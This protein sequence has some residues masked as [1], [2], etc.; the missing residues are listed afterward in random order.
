MSGL[1]ESAVF[2]LPIEAAVA[3]L[4]TPLLLISEALLSEQVDAFTS[5]AKRMLPAHHIHYSV[6]TNDAAPVVEAMARKLDGLEVVSGSELE[7]ALRHTDRI[8]FN[9]PNKSDR[10]L[11]TALRSNVMINLDGLA[12][13][14]RVARIAERLR[15]EP[16]VGVRVTFESDDVWQKF[17]VSPDGRELE[18]IQKLHT[19]TALHHHG[20]P[21]APELYSKLDALRRRLGVRTINLG[22]GWEPVIEIGGDGRFVRDDRTEKVFEQIARTF[23]DDPPSL[24]LEPGRAIVEAAIVA[25]ARI[26]NVKRDRGRTHAYVDLATGWV[27]GR[28]PCDRRVKFLLPS[29]GSLERVLIAGPMCSGS[30][31]L[32]E[33]ELR[34]VAEGRILAMANAGAYTLT[35]RWHGPAPKPAIVWVPLDGPLE[36]VQYS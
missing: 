16:R 29:E 25:V 18:E 33:A 12:D 22:G 21:F 30:D 8:I 11:E 27:G 20:D 6:K 5:L 4:G 14:R 23:A 28:H 17:G 3:E 36:R 31:I 26:G 15:V 19:I 10:E 7:V 35:L 9:G 24:I 32:G 34:G 13:A 1:H 2:D